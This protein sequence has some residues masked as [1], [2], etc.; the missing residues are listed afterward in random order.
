M[1]ELEFALNRTYFI[2]TIINKLT[3]LN[4]QIFQL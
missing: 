1:I 4:L 3:E 2:K